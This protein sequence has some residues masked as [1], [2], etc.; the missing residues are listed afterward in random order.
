M[1][2]FT[3]STTNCFGRPPRSLTKIA[4]EKLPVG[5]NR[6][7]DRIVFQPAT[8]FRGKLA[9]ELP[10][11][12]C[13]LVAFW[14]PPPLHPPPK[15]RQKISY[16]GTDTYPTLTKNAVKSSST[17]VGSL[18]KK[19]IIM[20]VPGTVPFSEDLMREGLLFSSENWM[21]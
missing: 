2:M 18:G 8:I 10:G 5:P 16:Q 9:V 12:V 15:K 7:L 4:P 20:L 21:I 6:K 1:I 14:K 3:S 19:G 13:G 11:V 17:Q